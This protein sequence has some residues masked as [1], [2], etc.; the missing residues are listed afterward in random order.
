MSAPAAKFH[1]DTITGR[2]LYEFA[3]GN[4]A[5][6]AG[7]PNLVGTTLTFEWAQLEPAAGQFDWSR[8]DSAIAPWAA[9][10]KHVILRVSTAG[11]AAW[12]SAAADA[13]PAWVYAQGVPSVNDAGS[14]LPVYWNP[15]FLKD[16]GAFIAAYA[17]HYDGNPVVSFIEMGIGD[18]GETLPDTQEGGTDH[19]AQ[20]TPY[21]YSDAVWLSTIESIA[22][23]FRNDFTRTPVV[24]LVDSSFMGP[25]R[26][27]DYPA[28]TGWFATNGFPMQYDGLTS[29]TTPQDSDWDRT[30][31]VV[32]Q[33]NATSSSGDTLA[34]DCA[35]AI[36]PMKSNVFLIYQSDIEASGNQTAL[37]ACAAS[38]AS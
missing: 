4:S 22:T 7:N 26:S 17:A 11:Q 12:G 28:L 13:T 35:D 33:R 25:S 19:F 27:T 16:Y 37:A 8:V 24:P 21:G 15:T 10:G 20:W 31:V 6:D 36:G 23:T 3:G 9:A 1:P 14:I 29:T 5:T 32:E 30:T 2:G 38:V 34:G 18:G